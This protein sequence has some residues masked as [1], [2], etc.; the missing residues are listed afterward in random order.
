M[1]DNSTFS[2]LNHDEDTIEALRLQHVGDELMACWA[3][4]EWRSMQTSASG[5]PLLPASVRN[6]A[7]QSLQYMLK[8]LEL[9]ADE[10]FTAATVFDRYC[11]GLPVDQCIRSLPCICCAIARLVKTNDDAT[12]SLER[13]DW[14]ELA[15]QMAAW[16]KKLGYEQID[17][18]SSL[19][20]I[21]S[22]ERSVIDAMDWQLSPPT[23]YSWLLAF[24]T[25][26]DVLTQREYTICLQWA[27]SQGF[28]CA[29]H[30]VAVLNFA[31]VE[32]CTLTCGLLALLL[33]SAGLLDLQDVRPD[34][35]GEDEW[36]SLFSQAQPLAGGA[37]QCALEQSRRELFM[38]RFCETV[39]CKA[40]S[41]KDHC[42]AAACALRQAL[43]SHQAQT[44]RPAC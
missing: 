39:G 19:Q 13:H 40:V 20:D 8:V 21:R 25:R 10:W 22:A 6:C 29:T 2:A 35:L 41:V 18:P 28:P 14:L 37:P 42:H 12:S 30:L 7:L 15:V 3:S 31:E 32:P 38:L 44:V 17:V 1:S 34:S 36:L 33:V 43:A 4:R 24:C 26:L 11:H 27:W 5:T 23:I 9:P 16:L